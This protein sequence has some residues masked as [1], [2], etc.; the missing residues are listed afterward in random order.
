VHA[1]RTDLAQFYHSKKPSL[2]LQYMTTN[3]EKV[4]FQINGTDLLLRDL[5]VYCTTRANHRA[6]I[7]QMKQLAI[8]NN[9]S[10]AS[11]YDLGNIIQSESMAELNTVL[12]ANERKMEAQRREQLESQEKMK[13]MEIEAAQKEQQM[14]LEHDMMEKEKDRRRDLLV[15]EIRASGYG[16]TADIN[17]NLESDYAEQMKQIRESEEFQQTMNLDTQKET[18]KS[19]QFRDKQSLEREKL[20]AQMNIKQTELEIA[21]ENKNKYDVKPPE[22]KSDKKKK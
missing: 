22:K 20:Q 12:K 10:G 9:T 21:R 1:L 3:D 7:E 8:Q 16:S 14:Q 18:A 2:R 15:A 4:N 11:I 17:Q 5:N 6:I 19:Q 13:Q